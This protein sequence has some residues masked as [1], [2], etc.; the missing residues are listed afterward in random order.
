MNVELFIKGLYTISIE[1]DRY[2]RF[3]NYC[4]RN[5]I[6]LY[7]VVYEEEYTHFSLSESDFKRL[8]SFFEKTNI[9]Y[10]ILARKGLPN[11]LS[12]K[13]SKCALLLLAMYICYM[14][15]MSRYIWNIRINGNLIYSDE[16][17]MEKLHEK[18][19]YIGCGKKRVNCSKLEIELKEELIDIKWISI[20][21]KGTTVNVDIYD[22]VSTENDVVSMNN[23]PLV[24]DIDCTITNIIPIS[25]TSVV[26]IG[27]EV[28]I[29]DVLISN[30]ITIYNDYGEAVDMA[31][32][33][34][35]GYVEGLVK[36]EYRDEIMLCRYKKE[37][38]APITIYSICCGEAEIE[39]FKPKGLG[40]YDTVSE[41][42]ESDNGKDFYQPFKL[43]KKKIYPYETVYV[44][45]S[46][47]EV[48]AE[49]NKRLSKKELDLQKKGVEIVENNVKI[50]HVEG[51]Y[52]AKGYISYKTSVGSKGD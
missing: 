41:L 44:E 16:Q 32:V 14:L 31:Y 33:N 45:E 21:K 51:G 26:N 17:I 3:A 10:S 30:E 37:Y 39:L 5:N 6:L 8:S 4:S 29:G 15:I 40:E 43:R 9:K 48:K 52:V 22:A 23:N 13:V 42:A 46:E 47:N 25:G 24:S 19:V 36:E 27:D 35:M 12:K 1:T 28:H 20:S 49:L 7:D 11:I 38:K 34:A 50:Y 18:N 2:L